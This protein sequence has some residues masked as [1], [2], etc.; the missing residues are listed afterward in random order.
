[1][2]TKP[3]F[4]AI[5]GAGVLGLLGPVISEAQTVQ[6]DS[7]RKALAAL[8]LEVQVQQKTIADNQVQIEAKLAEIADSIR[9]ARIY[10]SRGGR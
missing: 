8:L 1:M 2:K 6:T 5:V 10:V 7:E 4:L 9:Q 3:I